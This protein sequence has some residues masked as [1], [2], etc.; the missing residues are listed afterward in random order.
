MSSKEEIE[1]F[2]LDLN[3]SEEGKRMLQELNPVSVQSVALP[4]VE[5]NKEINKKQTKKKKENNL[6][7]KTFNKDKLKKPNKAGVVYLRNNGNADL[8]QVNTVNGFFSIESKIYHED[9]DCVYTITKDRTPL[10]IVREWDLIPLGT[11]KWEDEPMRKKF[12]EL[13][14]HVLKGIR[15]AELVK[16][17]GAGIDSKLTPKQ[18]IL[19]GLAALVGV[20]VLTNFI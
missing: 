6:W 16:S 5:T 4:V 10:L 12:A 20:I 14:Q 15:Q 13:E 11:K 7:S 19:W 17:G 8:M 9:R 3:K 1:K 2:L 18:L